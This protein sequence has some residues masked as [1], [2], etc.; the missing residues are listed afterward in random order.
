[1]PDLLPADYRFSLGQIIT[2]REGNDA[3]I[4][5]CGHMVYTSLLAAEAL[6]AQG[7]EATVANVSTIKPL[8]AEA[9]LALTAASPLVVTVEAQHHRRARLRRGRGAGRGGPWPAAGAAGYR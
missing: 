8:N 3:T 1:M 4:L 2:L 7:I 6:A 9:V 5:A